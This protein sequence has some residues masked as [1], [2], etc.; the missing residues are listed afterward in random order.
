MP[1]GSLVIGVDLVPIKPVRGVRTLMGDITTQECR[2]AIKREAGGA[3]M[4]VVLHDGAPNVGGAWSSEAYSQSWLTLESLR[5]ATDVLAPRGTFITKVFRSKD[6]S[7]LLYALKQL[8]AKVEAT[9]PAASRNASAEI[10]VVCQGYKAPAKIDPRLL[11][12]R[13]LFQEVDEPAKLAGP[14]A[15]LKD[16]VKQRR[17]REGYE[18]GMTL[19]RRVAPAAAFLASDAPVE[20]LGRCTE[21][22]LRGAAAEGECKA[23][24][25]GRGG[26]PGGGMGGRAAGEGSLG[27]GAACMRVAPWCG[28]WRGGGP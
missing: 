19:A 2:A 13:H 28:S 23:S 7:A 8:F 17:F 26:M 9:K 27:W 16:K 21:F 3:L 14:D 15:L 12:A 10:F 6:Y 25:R 18:E 24:A 20:M 5:M 4:D 1:V 22:A 11:D